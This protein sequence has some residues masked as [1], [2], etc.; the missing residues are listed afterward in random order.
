MRDSKANSYEVLLYTTAI[1]N[2]VSDETNER[3]WNERVDLCTAAVHAAI[4]DIFPTNAQRWAFVC[5]LIGGLKSAVD[6]QIDSFMADYARDELG[7]D[8]EEEQ[9]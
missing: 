3:E 8:D 2:I 1:G 7:L 4:E 6:E 9:R 5:Q